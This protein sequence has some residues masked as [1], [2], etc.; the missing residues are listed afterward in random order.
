MDPKMDVGPNGE[1]V[2][3][4][5][6]GNHLHSLDASV[7]LSTAGGWGP[8]SKRGPQKEFGCFKRFSV[9]K[10]LDS[11]RHSLDLKPQ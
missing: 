10:G 8:P 2:S 7:D 11:C 1:V 5:G 9:H 4:K 6:L 3:H